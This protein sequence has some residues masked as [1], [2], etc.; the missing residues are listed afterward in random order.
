MKVNPVKQFIKSNISRFEK[1]NKSYWSNRIFNLYDK[2]NSYRG[3]YQ[4]TVN[5]SSSY[6]G[7]TNSLS[8]T[9]ILN[10]KLKQEMAEYVYMDKSFINIYD[11]Q[12]KDLLKTKSLPNEITTTTTILDFVNDKFKTL[13][14]VSKLKNKLQRRMYADNP[15][16]VYSNNFVVYEP[17]KE[18]PQYE[19]SVE[20]VR[21]GSIS[22]INSKNQ[23]PYKY[24]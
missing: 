10:D 19:K 15:D 13:R 4:F 8:S 9:R 20:Y 12:S 24:W 6:N 14:S 16:F 1:D 18:K 17:L 2:N 5:R 7:V 21:E 23:I 3:E 22:K 11:A